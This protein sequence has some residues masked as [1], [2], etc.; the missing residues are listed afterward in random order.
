MPAAVTAVVATS[1]LV[2]PTIHP[3]A[4]MQR[5]RLPHTCKKVHLFPSISS[6]LP[7]GLEISTCSGRC[8]QGARIIRNQ[9]SNDCLLG[10]A[11]GRRYR[12]RVRVQRQPRRG[13]PKKILLNLYIGSERPKD[14]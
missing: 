1:S 6:L 9:K 2:L 3:K 10:L 13:M 8:S 4:V 5:L 12:L 14:T 11:L 7:I